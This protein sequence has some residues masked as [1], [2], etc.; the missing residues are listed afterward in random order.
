MFD[1][2][3]CSAALPQLQ[4][5]LRLLDWLYIYQAIEIEH[6]MIAIL[7]MLFWRRGPEGLPQRIL[8]LLYR[9]RSMSL[10]L[11]LKTKKGKDNTQ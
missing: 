11:K 3:S 2:T 5:L 4:S 10:V 1:F 8:E 9:I 7:G 6:Q